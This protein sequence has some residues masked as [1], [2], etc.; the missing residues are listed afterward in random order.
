MLIVG[1]KNYFMFIFLC[2]S[3]FGGTVCASQHLLAISPCFIQSHSYSEIRMSGVEHA[4][5]GGRKEWTRVAAGGGAGAWP[6]RHG[7]AAAVTCHRRE[8]ASRSG[9]KA[10]GRRDAWGWRG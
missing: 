7:A 8:V 10:D 6:G 1:K 2:A 3:D 5:G 9:G 4:G